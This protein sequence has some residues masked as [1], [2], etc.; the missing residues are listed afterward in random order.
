MLTWISRL[1]GCHLSGS[2][3]VQRKRSETQYA[4]VNNKFALVD[5]SLSSAY[6][7]SSHLRH[8]TGL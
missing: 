2:A 4:L 8:L 3:Q 5:R 7:Q 6:H 1:S